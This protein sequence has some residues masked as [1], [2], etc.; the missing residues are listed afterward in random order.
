MN[1]WLGTN[2]LEADSQFLWT[3]DRALKPSCRPSPLVRRLD[4]VGAEPALQLPRKRHL[5]MPAFCR[6]RPFAAELQE[7]P[8]IQRQK[9]KKKKKQA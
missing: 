4:V 2:D 5:L 3:A 6:V 9:E 7:N 1:F 8:E